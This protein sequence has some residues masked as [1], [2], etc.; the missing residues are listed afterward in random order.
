MKK[1]KDKK[2][3]KI[4][5][6]TAIFAAGCFW[7]VQVV[8]DQVPGVTETTAGYIG[9]SKMFK[10]PA[11]FTLKITIQKDFSLLNS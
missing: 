4:K 3:K 10:N 11:G 5:T 9:G 1:E 7:G 2:G 6:E 8:F